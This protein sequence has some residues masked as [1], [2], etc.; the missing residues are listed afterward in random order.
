MHSVRKIFREI[1]VGL[2]V[3]SYSLTIIPYEFAL[4][5]DFGEELYDIA[6]F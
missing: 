6:S 1:L 4:R 5:S 3:Y 2:E